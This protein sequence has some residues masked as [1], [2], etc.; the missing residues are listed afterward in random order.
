MAKKNKEREEE[1]NLFTRY[2]LKVQ[3]ESNF[4]EVSSFKFTP[5][6]AISLV[7]SILLIVIVTVSLLI[8]LTPVREL[9]PGYPD[10]KLRRQIENNL[11]MVDSLEEELE[12]RDQYFN[13][14]QSILT[15]RDIEHMETI[16]DNDS[17]YED[18]DFSISRED[19]LLREKVAREEQFSL[20]TVTDPGQNF[21]LGLLHFFPPV[22]GVVTSS[23][24]ANKNHFGTDIVA[25][26]NQAVSA[27][28]DGTVISSTWSLEFGYV[29]QIQHDN[30]L[31]SAYK[32][33]SELLKS[34][35]SR[36]KAG[37]A[38]AIIGNS[39]E[40]TTGPHLHFELW[41]NGAP[42]NPQEY[43]IF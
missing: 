35:G 38:I 20:L 11:M 25:P 26:P 9:I 6:F 42:L 14:I 37:E 22:K 28:L 2:L 8:A 43:I 39:G 17:S 41:Y 24:D 10:G 31:I 32:H 30:N 34:T 4:E 33:N 7:S 12:I 21:D 13:T 16:Q 29:I 27:V 19:S 23:F 15:G 18:I 5:F 36:V 1:R 40:L 3:Q